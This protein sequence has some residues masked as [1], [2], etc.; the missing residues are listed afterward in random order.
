MVLMEV[1]DHSWRNKLF[2]VKFDMNNSSV[3]IR[4]VS[5]ISNLYFNK[6]KLFYKYRKTRQIWIKLYLLK[7]IYGDLILTLIRSYSLTHI[8]NREAEAID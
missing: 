8:R 5:H 4:K 7:W 3:V 6:F 1:K 2:F